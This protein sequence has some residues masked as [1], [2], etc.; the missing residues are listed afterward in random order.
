MTQMRRY[1]QRLAWKKDLQLSNLFEIILLKG[2]SALLAVLIFTNQT[3][4][5]LQLVGARR[6]LEVLLRAPKVLPNLPFC[7]TFQRYPFLAQT[8]SL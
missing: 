7:R 2:H 1:F 3:M 5:I 8:L 6:I 4:N